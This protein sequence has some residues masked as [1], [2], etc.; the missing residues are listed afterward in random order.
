MFLRPLLAKIHSA[1]RRQQYQ[2]FQESLLMSHKPF[3]QATVSP[4][5]TGLTGNTR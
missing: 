5:K 4:F 2:S 1:E 3:R